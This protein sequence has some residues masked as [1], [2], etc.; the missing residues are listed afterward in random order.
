M[1]IAVVGQGYVG[2]SISIGAASNGHKV[3]G[4]DNDAILISKLSR[5]ET[6]VPNISKNILLDLISADK[7][8]PTTSFQEIA[9][10]SIVVIAVPTPLSINREPDLSLLIE[11]SYKIAENLT[12][13]CLLINES[14][15]HPGTLRN[16][17]KPI[18]E[19][20]SKL[21]HF[22]AAAPERIDPGN[23][24]WNL[25][26]TPRIIGG[27]TEE[28]G[29]LAEHF[30]KSFCLNV[31]RVSSPEVAEAAKL[32]ENTFRQINIALANEFSIIS[33][34]IGFSSSEAIKAASTKPFGFMSFYPSIGVGGHCIPVDPTYLGYAAKQV[35]V[36]AN[37]I[38]LANSINSKMVDY[39]VTKIKSKIETEMSRLRIQVAGIAY[40]PGVSDLRESP[41]LN[42]IS[43]L[44][45]EGAK[46]IWH[47]PLV[48]S[49][50][51]EKSSELSTSIDLGLIV[52]P[53]K[54]IDFSVWKNKELR[55]LDLS[56]NAEDYGWSKFL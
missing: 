32:F 25:K 31:L 41:A 43:E 50:N 52:T 16:V 8:K 13:K 18:I 21:T 54:V 47:D 49:W 44:R 17:I 1:N 56:A 23:D 14:T 22:Y 27:I 3:F 5:G 53:H 28:A 35:G 9:Q 36:E 34:K 40:K 42:L 46:V 26:N 38:D 6:H 19:A 12:N 7:F 51:S 39:V 45:K 29:N 2:L 37:F 33:D 30:Y 4:I 15:S 24:V 55:V 11:A 48:K 20:G 10:C